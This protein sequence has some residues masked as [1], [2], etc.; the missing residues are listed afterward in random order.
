[1]ST[2]EKA[3]SFPEVLQDIVGNIQDILRSEIRLAKTEMKEQAGMAGKAAGILGAGAL[4][5]AY[6]LCF[7]LAAGALALATVLPPWLAALIVGAG[8]GLIG[9]VLIQVGRKK[10]KRVEPAPRRAIDSV[11]EN[12]QWAKERTQ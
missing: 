12:L 1:M 3:R 6:A 9:A 5:A 4:L 10:M 8:S 2:G 7:L 11:K